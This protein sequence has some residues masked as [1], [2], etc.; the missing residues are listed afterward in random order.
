MPKRFSLSR[1]WPLGLL[2][3]TACA[4]S[5]PVET[6]PR[7]DSLVELTA[8][9][10]D[11]VLDIRYATANNFTGKAVYPSSRCFLDKE[12]ACAL[13]RVQRELKDRGYRLKVYD[14]YRPLSV[15]Q[16]FWKILPD[17]RFVADP[18]V[19]SRHN[20]GCAVDVSLVRLDGTPVAMPT[21][22]DDFTE[23]ASAD[24]AGLPGDVE[25]RR[26]LLRETME[27]HG[28]QRF[29]TEW[30]HFD[31]QGWQNRPVLDVPFESIPAP[32]PPCPCD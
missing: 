26:T 17:P 23:R 29:D 16:A 3:L 2:L 32:S 10:P 19:G 15:Q 1:A 7:T 25:Q 21:E 14:G 5:T 13:V 4:G 27:R 18:K 9:I 12:A 8:C 22:Y 28:F 31:Y 24:Y 6:V 11:L 20:R 30:W